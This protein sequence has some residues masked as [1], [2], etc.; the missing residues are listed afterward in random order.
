VFDWSFPRLAG[1]E[2][3]RAT[4]HVAE[5]SSALRIAFA[6]TYNVGS[7][8]AFERALLRAGRYRAEAR[9]RSDCL[10][11]NEGIGLRIYDSEDPRR[12][13]ESTERLVGSHD[14]TTIGVDFAVAEPTLVV[15]AITRSESLKF[16]NKVSGTVWIDAVRLVRR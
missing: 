6:G 2:A 15:V 8:M 10:T 12:L 1:A 14:W 16:D 5:G 9:I 7:A 11:T 3:T 4:D 13:N